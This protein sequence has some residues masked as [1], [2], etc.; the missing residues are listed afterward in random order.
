MR[1]GALVL[2]ESTGPRI[3]AGMA[4]VLTGVAMTRTRRTSE[5]DA[6]G[7]PPAAAGASAP[8]TLLKATQSRQTEDGY[9]AASPP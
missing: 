8:V 1:L 2:N 4:V 5:G 9:S 6:T 3:W 7:C